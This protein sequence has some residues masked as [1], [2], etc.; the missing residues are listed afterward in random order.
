MKTLNAD[1]TRVVYG[2]LIKCE[3]REDASGVVGST[4]F[5]ICNNPP[6]CMLFCC[7]IVRIGNFWLAGEYENGLFLMIMQHPK[8][9]G[10]CSE[11][12][13]YAF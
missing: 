6:D 4:Q 10:F 3:C 12:K 8:Y 13:V 5:V 1:L 9:F 2:G 7:N 11:K